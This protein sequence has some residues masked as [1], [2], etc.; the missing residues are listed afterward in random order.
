MQIQTRR[1]FLQSIALGSMAVSVGVDL[2]AK[3][4]SNPNR[5]QIGIQEYTFNRLL[6]SGKLKHLNYPSMV[7]K[8]LGIEHV[9]YWSR[10]FEGKH[11]DKKF[12][13]ELLRRTKG[14]GISNVLILV[15]EKHEL[16]H[17][18]KSERDLSVDLHKGWI[19]CAAQLGCDAI[20]VNCRMGGDPKD[21]LKRAVDGVGRLCEYAKGTPVKVV[22]EPHGRNSQNPDWLLAVMKELD[23]S[24]AG[25]LP[26][27]NNFG[28]Y[29][30]YSAVEKT[31]PYAPAV[32]AKALK[33][34][35]EG[36]EIHTDY[37]KMLKIVHDSEFSG[38]ISIEFEGHGVDPIVGS[39]MTK[40]LILEGLKRARNS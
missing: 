27:F 39:R 25:I 6:R 22:I 3:N 8:E 14:E 31:L 37:F 2:S 10:P 12:V 28:S 34:D 35:D 13:A 29:D 4:K 24:H 26:D 17:E 38:V 21:N 23:H 7:K 36:N 1:L 15:D 32:C 19:D 40:K 20:R 5:F 33:F 16:D 30:R 18:K 11:T 9:E